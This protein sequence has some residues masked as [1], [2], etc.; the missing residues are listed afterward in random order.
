MKR[1]PFVLNVLNKT[2]KVTNFIKSQSLGTCLFNCLQQTGKHTYSTQWCMS[3]KVPGQLG[4]DINW[5][6]FHI[7]P[8]L[9]RLGRHFL[10][11]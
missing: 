3:Q 11:R 1:K 9:F 5:L 7:I 4:Y 8:W 6:V 2:L 10:E